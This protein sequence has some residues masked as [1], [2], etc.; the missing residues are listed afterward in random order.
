[1]RRMNYPR[2]DKPTY[3]GEIGTGDNRGQFSLDHPLENGIYMVVIT[4][5]GDGDTY[6]FN[7]TV[8]DHLSAY[9]DFISGMTDSIVNITFIPNNRNVINITMD[10]VSDASTIELYKL[11]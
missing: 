6:T 1:M 11:N 9:A 8:K 2:F 5:Y 3:V 10:H 7:L 4:D